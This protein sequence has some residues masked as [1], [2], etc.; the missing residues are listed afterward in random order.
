MINSRCAF[1]SSLFLAEDEPICR[2]AAIKTFMG[3]GESP[4]SSPFIA[5]Q[6]VAASDVLLN[7]IYA[8]PLLDPSRSLSTLISSI[9][10]AI[11]L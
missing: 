2:L 3:R 5:S 4:I 6:A 7:L 10:P 1:S 11:K 8:T 9:R